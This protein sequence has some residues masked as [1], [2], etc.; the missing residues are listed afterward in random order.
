MAALV[1]ALNGCRLV[2]VAGAAACGSLAR[3]Q[4][5]RALYTHLAALTTLSVVFAASTISA[6]YAVAI[7]AS[8]SA[9]AYMPVMF[10]CARGILRQGFPDL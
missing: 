9:F 8:A 3:R 2:D 6:T 7:G 5:D 4:N 10:V 1:R